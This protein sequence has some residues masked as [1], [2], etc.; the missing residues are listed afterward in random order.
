M[1]AVDERVDALQL[2]PRAQHLHALHTIPGVV[3][4]FVAG[5]NGEG[6]GILRS[7]G[8]GTFLSWRAPG[9]S[10]FGASVNCG[11]DGEYIIEDGED[12]DS[13]VRVDVYGTYLTPGAAS[14]AVYLNDVYNNA[15]G[16]DNVSAAEAAAGDVE[17]YPVAIINNH[18]S[19]TLA[20]LRVWLDAA[21]SAGLK[22]SDD[23]ATWVNPTTE[24][25]AITLPDLA[26]SGLDT[27]YVQRTISAGATADPEVLNVLHLSHEGF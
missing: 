19:E 16:D 4:V 24:A 25:T 27:F 12:N 15:I 1:P 20:R 14:A 13:Y 23:D 21:A 5:Q 11:T 26:A 8:D 10:T 6:T 2:W 22:I 18:A 3:L 7:T 9:S 17:S